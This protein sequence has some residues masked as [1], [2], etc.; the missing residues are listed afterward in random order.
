[1]A[2]RF[3]NARIDAVLFDKDGTLFD[4]QKS[5]GALG[6]QVVETLSSGDRALALRL[7]EIAG[8]DLDAGRY[9]AGA[10][11]VAGAVREV[12]EAWAALLPA[13]QPPALETWLN[14]Q[15]VAISARGLPPATDDLPGLLDR[16]RAGGLAL[17]VAT[18]DAALSAKAHLMRAGAADRVD[19]IAG[20]DSGHGLKPGPGMLRA[21]CAAVAVAPD[22]VAVVGDSLHDLGMARSGGAAAAIGVLTGPADA[23]HLGP[24]ADLV[25]PSIAALPEALGLG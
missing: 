1:M 7:A 13:W 3:N 22:R 5:W 25:L 17:G 16:L 14:D 2:A 10:P 21:F 24:H 18:H 19:F 11:I 15:A 12:A 20:Y 4:F 8:Y 9:R 6:A 23:D